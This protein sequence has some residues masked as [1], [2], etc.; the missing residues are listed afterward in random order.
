M[1]QGFISREVLDDFA[2]VSD[3]AYVAQ[4]S[5]RIVRALLEIAM[6]QKWANATA[7]LI[8]MSKAIESRLW[9][10]DHPLRQFNLKAET[11]FS[12]EKWAD[13]WTISELASADAAVL[14]ALVHLNETHGRAILNAS[15]QFPCTQIDYT[16]QPISSDIL[17]ISLKITRAFDWNTKIHGTSE[18]FWIWI[19][20]RDASTILQLFQI[21]FHETTDALRT[22]FFIPIPSGQPAAF[23]TIRSISDRWVGAEDSMTI[24]LD[25]LIMPSASP[26][27]TPVLNLPFLGMDEI[28]SSILKDIFFSRLR[29]LNTLQ[30]QTFW[31]LIHTKRNSL[32]C[33]PAGSGK[34][35]LV[36]MA[37]W[38]VPSLLMLGLF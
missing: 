34:S 5:G 27:H 23:V 22:D 2:L 7:A 30:T 25:S 31:N 36:Q 1:L 33:A 21:V 37:V 16:L 20:D 4:N 28:G 38:C 10:F 3:M 12:L 17:K 18:Q 8:G 9:S 24:P 6:S 26:P 19:E 32:F 11:M 35:A 14:G 13:D 29:T 15:K